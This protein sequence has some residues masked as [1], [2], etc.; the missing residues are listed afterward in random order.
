[1]AEPDIKNDKADERTVAS[2]LLQDNPGLV[3]TLCYVSISMLGML[4]SWSL[5]SEFDVNIFNFTEASDFLL[6]ALREPMTF[7]MAGTA[8]LVTWSLIS[9]GKLEV[10]YFK[11]NPAKNRFSKYYAK[12]S[13]A[14]NHHPMARLAI[15][16]LYCY[17]FISLF[18]NWKADEIKAGNGKLIRVQLTEPIAGGS[19]GELRGSVITEGILLGSTNKYLFLYD[20][21]SGVMNAMPEENIVRVMIDT[22]AEE[23]ESGD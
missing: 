17:L 9:F 21:K 12:S 5:F 14:I 18:G 2:T 22:V 19:A 1:M 3:L 7:V 15:F 10:R 8:L 23:P 4:F 20:L 11:R 16:L 13:Q 6:A